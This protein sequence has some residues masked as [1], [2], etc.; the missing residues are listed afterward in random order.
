M[1]ILILAI[2]CAHHWLVRTVVMF[3]QKLHTTLLGLC[4]RIPKVVREVRQLAKSVNPWPNV[5]LPRFVCC[6]AAPVRLNRQR[7]T[8][9]FI[10]VCFGVFRLKDGKWQRAHGHTVH[11]KWSMCGCV[12]GDLALT[13]HGWRHEGWI[14]WERGLRASSIAIGWASQFIIQASWWKLFSP[15]VCGTPT[16]HIT[17]TVVLT[18][19]QT[20]QRHAYDWARLGRLQHLYIHV[21][22]AHHFNIRIWLIVCSMFMLCDRNVTPTHTVGALWFHV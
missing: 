2:R 13:K 16:Y 11:H 4:S 1:C 12:D 10:P 5:L 20:A 6:H 3:A 22:C 21:C 14:G 17:Y 8:H 19:L 9:D 15:R 7:A 18:L